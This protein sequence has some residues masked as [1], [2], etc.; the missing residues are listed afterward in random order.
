MTS[1]GGTEMSDRIRLKDTHPDLLSAEAVF[2]FM[3]DAGVTFW[4]DSYSMHVTVG[5]NDYVVSDAED[6]R[7]VMSLPPTCEY[8]LTIERSKYRRPTVRNDRQEPVQ[9]PA[10]ASE[11]V[12]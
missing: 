9:R 12:V 8:K 2:Q 4:W 3:E 7:A 6:D 11:K 10:E 5:D 1:T